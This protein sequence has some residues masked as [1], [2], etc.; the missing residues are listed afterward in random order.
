MTIFSKILDVVTGGT[1]GAVSG[2]AGGIMDVVTK[3]FPPDMTPEAKANLQLALDNFQLQKELQTQAAIAQAEKEVD[4]RIAMY[5][6]SASD[7]KTI[8]YLGALMLFLRGSQRPVWGFVV[9]YLD[10][11]VFSGMWK[12]GDPIVSNAFWI[13]N[14][15]VLGFLFGERAVMNVMPF[16]TNM[17]QVKN[18]APQDVSITT[19]KK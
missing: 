2:I 8:P 12:L 14:F 17:I 1:S 3:Y 16:V 11:G 15:L 6:G 19:V 9:M 10:Y 18:Q 7:L 13:L 5:E 4:D